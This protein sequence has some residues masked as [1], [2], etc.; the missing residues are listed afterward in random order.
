M[1]L[2]STSGDPRAQQL[3]DVYPISLRPTGAS[4]DLHARRVNH[5]ALDAT[6][7]E[8]VREPKGIVA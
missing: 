7:F 3:A 6:R 2:A 1:S 5:E 8:E 4:I